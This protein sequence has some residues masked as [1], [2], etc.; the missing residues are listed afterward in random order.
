MKI[1]KD[2][3]DDITYFDWLNFF[4]NNPEKNSEETKQLE[5]RNNIDS[6]KASLNNT[7]LSI[8]K[9]EILQKLNWMKSYLDNIDT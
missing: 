6:A 5:I 7:I 1:A 2:N 9:I 3:A 4:K 8:D